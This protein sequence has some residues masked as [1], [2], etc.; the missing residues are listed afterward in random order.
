[1]AQS[2]FDG[3]R[4]PEGLHGN[5]DLALFPYNVIDQGNGNHQCQLLTLSFD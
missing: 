2:Q 5:I 4:I 3:V 1:M